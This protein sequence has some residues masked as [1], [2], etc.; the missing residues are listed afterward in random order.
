MLA[1][2]VAFAAAGQ[3]VHAATKHDEGDKPLASAK[4][5][6]GLVVDILE[7]AREKDEVLKITWRYKNPTKKPVQLLA[8][9]PRF[10]TK[11]APA[12][13]ING[14]LRETYF[15]EGKLSD[16]SY[17]HDVLKYS[18]GK[19]RAKATSGKAVVLGPDEEYEFW[20]AFTLPRA[21]AKVITLHL[22]DTPP[23]ANLSLK[24]GAAAETTEN[25]KPPR[26]PAADDKS[27]DDYFREG[28]KL[29]QANKWDQAEQAFSKAMEL[30]PGNAAHV[31]ARALL[32]MDVGDV[33]LKAGKQEQAMAVYAKA[34]E[35]VQKAVDLDPL[36]TKAWNNAGVIANRIGANRDAIDFYTHAIECDPDNAVAYR[37]RGKTWLKLGKKAN[38]D[39]DIRKADK[40]EGKPTET[41]KADN[42]SLPDH[43]D[44][45]NLTDEQKAEVSKIMKNYDAKTAELKQK[46]SDASKIPGGTSIVIA[47]ANAIKKLKNQRQQA[48]EEVLTEEQRTKLH[49][50]R[51]G[52]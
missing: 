32:L 26:P 7:I 30:E 9:S 6:S 29:Q 18:D 2:V 49:D 13:T 1:L 45:L 20:A 8:P 39:A 42:A 43:F 34:L 15:Y 21:N 17:R 47:A 40:L 11:D 50:L 31:N 10:A 46:L 24:P 41:A 52:K 25:S 22:M 5:D 36:F 4:T 28:K 12:N 14:F 38:A 35:D 19:Y 37:N 48:L 44:Q 51:S 16:T 27:A 3:S 33:L 23:I